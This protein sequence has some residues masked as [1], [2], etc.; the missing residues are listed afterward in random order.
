MDTKD[1]YAIL[2]VARDADRAAITRACRRLMQRYHPDRCADP[3]AAWRFRDICEAGRVLRDAAQ[4]AAFD[5]SMFEQW[6]RSDARRPSR[7][8]GA[9][10]LHRSG[11]DIFVETFLSSDEFATGATLELTVGQSRLCIH[12]PAGSRVGQ[13]LRIHQR[14]LPMDEGGR[15]DLLVI[16]RNADERIRAAIKHDAGVSVRTGQII[17]ILC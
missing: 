1:Y 7:R 16:L 9:I 15:G 13:K 10:A 17:D 2:G 6:A 3:R 4:R 12:V 11:R 5:R 8:C 14:G